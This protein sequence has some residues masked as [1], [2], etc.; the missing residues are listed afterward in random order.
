MSFE[1]H[2]TTA[3][4]LITF[5]KQHAM[6]YF[7]HHT[8]LDHIFHQVFYLQV[9]RRLQIKSQ[10]WIVFVCP[11]W[12]SCVMELQFLYLFFVFLF[13]NPQSWS[14]PI[15]PPYSHDWLIK[16][17]PNFW[18]L[19]DN[20]SDVK[21]CLRSSSP[22]ANVCIFDCFLAAMRPM[23]MKSFVPYDCSIHQKHTAL[24]AACAWFEV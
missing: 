7:T 16:H 21:T 22:L 23:V 11:V 17:L 13:E 4:S 10:H 9:I 15:W 3:S 1:P 20:C 6:L 18:R 2:H 14:W 19:F 5:Q 24:I 12:E 8:Q